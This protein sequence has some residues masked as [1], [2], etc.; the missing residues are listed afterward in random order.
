MFSQPKLLLRW[1]L[2]FF[3]L[4]HMLISFIFTRDMIIA[5]ISDT[6]NWTT[7]IDFSAT[8]I[9]RNSR[10]IYLFKWYRYSIYCVSDLI[11][12]LFPKIEQYITITWL[13]ASLALNSPLWKKNIKYWSW[14]VLISSRQK[15][16]KLFRK[17]ASCW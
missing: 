11:K 17:L 8:L 15:R 5:Y 2:L 7:E 9:I 3:V 6:W 13:Y 4:F 1:P 14:S 10:S 16:M 12:Y